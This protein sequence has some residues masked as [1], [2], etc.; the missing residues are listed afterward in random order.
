M[1]SRILCRQPHGLQ[2]DVHQSVPCIFRHR[3]DGLRTAR[4]TVFGHTRVVDQNI[5]TACLSHRLLDHALNVGGF[6]QVRPQE[7]SLRAD[8]PNLLRDRLTARLLG[9]GNRDPG[10]AFAGDSNGDGFAQALRGT[11][12]QNNASIQST[13]GR[14]PPVDFHRSASHLADAF[15]R[16]SPR[17]DSTVAPSSAASKFD[18]ILSK[19]RMVTSKSASDTPL[20]VVSLTLLSNSLF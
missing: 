14:S 12:D 19:V 18:F 15:S 6:A 2:I 8:S 7:Q 10:G 11:R 1:G 16:A 3:L 17:V 20:N 5:E 9:V 13:H 4:Q